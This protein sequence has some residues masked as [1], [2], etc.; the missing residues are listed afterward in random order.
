[1]GILQILEEYIAGWWL[2]AWTSWLTMV[3]YI[4][5]GWWY[6]Y[7]SEKYESQMG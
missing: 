7:S 4:Y 6:T 3:I 2:I 5:S 1:M